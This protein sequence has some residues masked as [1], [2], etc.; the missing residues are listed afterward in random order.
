MSY[1]HFTQKIRELYFSGSFSTRKK[2]VNF[3]DS[4]NEYRDVE[5]LCQVRN[6]YFPNNS[7]SGK[8]L[9]LKLIYPHFL[10]HLD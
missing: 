1:V 2:K 8:A 5:L 9:L 4:R 7:K 3:V 6:K 10:D